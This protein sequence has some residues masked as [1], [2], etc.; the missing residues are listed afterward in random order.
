[1]LRLIAF[2]LLFLTAAFSGP[3]NDAPATFRDGVVLIRFREGPLLA[4]MNGILASVGAIELKQIGV[5]VHVLNVGPGR[6]LSTIQA[7]Q[8]LGEILYAEP[9]YLHQIDGGTIPNDTFAGSQWAMQN[10]GQTVNGVSGTPGADQRSPA[11]WGVTTGS[12]S[13]VVAVVDTGVQ[14]THPDLATNMWNNPGGIGGCPA[15]THGYNVVT[16]TCDPMDDDNSY[17]GHGTHVSGII[18]A[19]ANNAA[20][21]AE[22]TGP[23]ASW[24]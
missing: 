21:V 7:L 17:G 23:P 13:V 24:P 12:N 15:G 5:G 4:R 16:S 1:M 3:R 10:T 2:A 20:G 11:A 6:V 14:Y 22:R 9:D 18:G 19:V 8:K